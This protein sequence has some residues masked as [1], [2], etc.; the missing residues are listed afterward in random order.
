MSCEGGCIAGGGQPRIHF[1]VTNDIKL[2]R[3][4]GLYKADLKDKFRVSDENPDIIRIYKDFLGKPLSEKSHEL[5]HTKYINRKK[6]LGDG[7][8]NEIK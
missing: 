2:A 5:L 7:I 1:P 3:M 4:K 6:E 8:Y